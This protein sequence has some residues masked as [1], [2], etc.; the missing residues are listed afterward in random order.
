MFHFKQLETHKQ[1]DQYVIEFEPENLIENCLEAKMK[2]MHKILHGKAD[3]PHR[4]YGS[5]S[6]M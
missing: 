6:T 1:S 5:L 4:I 3:G 2:Y